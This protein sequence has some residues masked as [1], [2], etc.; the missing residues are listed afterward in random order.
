MG[1]AIGAAGWRRGYVPLQ[2]PGRQSANE[3]P[4]GEEGGLLTDLHVRNHLCAKS[5]LA[6]APLVGVVREAAYH[7]SAQPAH[8]AGRGK[9]CSRAGKSSKVSIVD[10]EKGRAVD[11][12]GASHRQAVGARG[13]MADKEGRTSFAILMN[14]TEAC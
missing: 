5:L 13:D 6:H 1:Q 7:R 11:A 12:R 2:L 10:V 9:S 3:F 14:C 8:R 4:Q